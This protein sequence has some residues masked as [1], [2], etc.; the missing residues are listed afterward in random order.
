MT[1]TAQPVEVAAGA[2]HGAAEAIHGAAGATAGA[3]SVLAHAGPGSTWQ[4]MVVV[5]GVVLAGYVIVAASGRI[6]IERPDDLVVPVAAAA[7][8][9]GIG[10][11]GHA[12]LSD[13][14][15]WGLPLA[16]TALLT[17]TLAATTPLDVRLPGP[18]PMGAL[19][20]ALVSTITL[21]QPL[22]IALHPP[23]EFLPLAE[24]ARIAIEE[25]A[26]E[27][28]VPAGTVEVTVVT[29]E[30][31]IGPGGLELDELDLARPAHAGELAV[32]R[33]AVDAD[34]T[35]SDRQRVASDPGPDCTV[36]D[37]CERATIDLDLEPGTWRITVELRR[38]DGTELAPTVTDHVTVEVE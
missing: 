24:D 31:S 13:F 19:A 18:L 2:S 36:A 27:A 38:G 29:D 23:P 20:V 15:G 28:T 33:A 9:G 4:A 21:Y 17:L 14:I 6:T 11:V 34:G 12:V 3:A 37:P 35:T 1:G 26:D 16:V 8:A 32:R 7:I 22:T 25:P 10:V 30:A 5:A